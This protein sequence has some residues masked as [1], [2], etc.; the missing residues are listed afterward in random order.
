MFILYKED[1]TGLKETVW[2]PPL[3]RPLRRPPDGLKPPARP[4]GGGGGRGGGG[5]GQPNKRTEDLDLEGIT[6]TNR[7]KIEKNTPFQCCFKSNFPGHTAK[8]AQIQAT[9]C[10]S[11]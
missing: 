10:T 7:E 6:T 4:P 8:A 5:G 11:H 9:F 3:G 1:L 2:S